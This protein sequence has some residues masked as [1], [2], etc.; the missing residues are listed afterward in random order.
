MKEIKRFQHVDDRRVCIEG[1][2]GEEV[3]EM[4]K[5]GAQTSSWLVLLLREPNKSICVWL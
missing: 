1:G 2:D 3:M 5:G 4:K